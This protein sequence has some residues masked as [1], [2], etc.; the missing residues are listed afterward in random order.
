VLVSRPAASER[1]RLIKRSGKFARRRKQTGTAAET[2]W[3]DIRGALGRAITRIWHFEGCIV[4]FAQSMNR[5]TLLFW[6]ISLQL[7]SMG[8]KREGVVVDGSLKSLQILCIVMR[9]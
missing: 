8:A 6:T 7:K 9:I 4:K 5:F 3:G 1:P 2:C